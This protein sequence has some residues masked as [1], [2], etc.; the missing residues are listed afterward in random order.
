MCVCVRVF[1]DS[2]TATHH[3]Q[4]HSPDVVDRV[5]RHPMLHV[6]AH[7][8]VGQW[9]GCTQID[10]GHVHT[11]NVQPLITPL[12]ADRHATADGVESVAAVEHQLQQWSG[13]TSR[14][15]DR[16]THHITHQ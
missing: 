9:V 7:T 4:T 15:A 6:W 2:L 12:A 11:A 1:T 8:G 10:Q 3:Q 5:E 16:H 13:D 14:E